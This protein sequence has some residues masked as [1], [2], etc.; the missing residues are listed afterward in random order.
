MRITRV[1]F[2]PILLIFLLIFRAI[3]MFEFGE[4]DLIKLESVF[5]GVVNCE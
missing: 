4:E 1:N 3:S 2:A 5:P